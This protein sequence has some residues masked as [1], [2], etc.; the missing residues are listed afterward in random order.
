MNTTT[1]QILFDK[2]TSENQKYL[3]QMLQNY[4]FTFQ[5]SRLLLE[6]MTDF[7]MWGHPFIDIAH[8]SSLPSQSKEQ[9]KKILADITKKWQNLKEQPTRYSYQSNKTRSNDS[10]QLKFTKSQKSLND[11]ILGKCPVASEKTLCC[12]LITLDAIQNCIFDCSYCSI[13]AFYPEKKVYF[14]DK[15]KEK[16]DLLKFD[17]QKKYHIGTGQS[18]D[19][20]ATGNHEKTLEHLFNFARKHRNIIL[21]LKTKSKNINYLIKNDI[22]KNVICT[23]SLNTQE[24]INEE[25]HYTASLK[26][27]LDCAKIIANKGNLVGFH[28]HPMIYCENYEHDYA[29]IATDI[30]NNFTPKEVA[31]ISFGTL[32]YTKKVIKTIREKKDLTKVLQIPF[33]KT[34]G[35]FSYPKEIKLKLFKNIYDA[36]SVWHKDVFFYLCME[37]SDYW[38]DVF[39]YQYS[40]N[41]QFENAMIDHYFQKVDVL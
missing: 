3:T 40:N 21:E 23:W 35:K 5:Q 13:Q 14:E 11:S 19:S 16:L 24:I 6:I 31:L 2:L 18:S 15:L 26:E 20:L 27:R 7:E 38:Q 33:D 12:N 4:Q 34:A 30:I 22:P 25:E 36:F 8:V 10:N 41:E 28:F 9:N 37:E 39:N 17:P 32:T 1:E 29:K